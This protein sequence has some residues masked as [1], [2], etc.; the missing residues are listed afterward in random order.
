MKD[1][2]EYAKIKLD[3]YCEE[4]VKEWSKSGEM[5]PV[6]ASCLYG[7]LSLFTCACV[8]MQTEVWIEPLN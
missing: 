1:E 8:C 5:V 4:E 6:C 7:S 2:Q 3:T